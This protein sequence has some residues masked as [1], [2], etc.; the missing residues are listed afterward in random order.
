MTTKWAILLLALFFPLLL[1]AQDEPPINPESNRQEIV[2][3]EHETARAIL[4]NNGTFFRR[5][6]SDDFSGTLSHGQPVDKALLIH[7]I[8]DRSFRYE[9]F[10]ASDI[11]VHIFQNTA[12]TSC[13][14][15]Y[16]ITLK[17][18]HVSTQLR[19]IHVYVNSPRGWQVVAG[20]STAL[21]PDSPRP[22]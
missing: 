15:S 14:W 8:E 7:I 17:G 9:S 3:L 10:N 20:Q 6:Y 21:P 18:Q 4:Q 1:R 11:K 22:L 19:T 12:V 5:V 16:V 2:N 13:L